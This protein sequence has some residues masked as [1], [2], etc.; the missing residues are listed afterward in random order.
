MTISLLLHR[1]RII[2]SLLCTFLTGSYAQAVTADAGPDKMICPASSA[3]IGGSPSASAGTA[4]YAYSWFPATGLSSAVV[5][6]PVAF[7]TTPT[8]YQLIVTDANA[9]KDT[10]FVFVDI[11]PVYQFNAGQDTSICIGA[12]LTLGAAANSNTNGITFSWSPTL[13]LDN[14]T[15]PRPIYTPIATGTITY[16]VTITSPNCPTKFSTIT[17]TTHGLPTINAGP[18]VTIQEGQTTTLN[19]TGGVIYWWTGNNI[20]YNGTYNPDVEPPQTSVYIVEAVDENGCYGNDSVIV[21]VIPNNELVFY[22][23]FTPNN[24]GDNDTWYIGN[25]SK[26]P[27]NRIE[28]FNRYGG[29]VYAKASYDNSWD[30]TNFGDKLPEATYYFILDLGNGEKVSGSV[31]IVR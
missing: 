6:N 14:P 26:Y 31:T 22:N 27:N 12:S 7:P 17:V 30:G 3:T 25:L 13:F 5:P 18:D 23:T 16:T 15:A 11:N 19:A 20:N 28:V 10:D 8:W 2:T 1:Y 4:P 21:Y 24:D 9:Q 29:L